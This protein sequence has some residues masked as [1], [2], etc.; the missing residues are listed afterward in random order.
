MSSTGRKI[1]YV[2]TAD[3]GD[4]YCESEHLLA[5]VETSEEADRLAEEARA[6][7]GTGFYGNVYKVWADVSVEEVTLGDLRRER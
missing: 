1:V 5:V 4:Y 3:C 6:A 2:V 7:T